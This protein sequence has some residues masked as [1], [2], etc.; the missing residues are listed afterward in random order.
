MKT[1]VILGS[2]RKDSNTLQAVKDLCPFPEYEVI[3]LLELRI[4]PY[5]YEDSAIDDFESIARKMAS[6]D[7][8]IFATPVYW[9][10]MSGN[11]KNFFD[12]LTDLLGKYK[13]IGKSLAGKST[14]LI[15]T[16]SDQEL[17][18]GFEEPFRRTSEYFQMSF[19]ETYYRPT[20]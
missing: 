16:G 6:A 15:A 14:Y 5:L 4:Y 3:N 19:R 11:M 8:I 1:I 18:V 12:R 2:S 17:P 10:S 13:S 20:K 9:Y 7:N